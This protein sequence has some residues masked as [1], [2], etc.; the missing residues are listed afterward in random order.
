MI[1]IFDT[2]E[3]KPFLFSM[4][5]A[6]VKKQKLD[7]GD[8]TVDGYEN[9]IGIDRKFGISEMYE[10]FFMGYDRFKKELIRSQIFRAFYF[11]CEFPYSD[12]VNFPNSMP[13][14]KYKFTASHII[15]KIK[16][17]EE[18]YGVTFIFC[19]S[20]DEAEQKCYQIL[21][22]FYDKNA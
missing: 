8:Y 18:K 4:Y 5:G 7:T 2:R 20:R 17:I 13:R 10:N 12:V 15:D 14:G 11:V 22:E 16:H 19:N 21:K 3:K 9:I 6:E 1:I